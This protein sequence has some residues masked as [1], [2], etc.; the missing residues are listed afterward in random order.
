MPAITFTYDLCSPGRFFASNVLKAALAHI[1]LNY[2]MK[3]AGDGSR[4]RD[5][6]ASLAVVPAPDGRVLFRKREG[7]RGV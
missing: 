7:S 3:L 1:V 6:Y 4:P 2:D 5:I